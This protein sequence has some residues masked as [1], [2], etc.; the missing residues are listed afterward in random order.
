MT[1]CVRLCNNNS[2]SDLYPKVAQ[3]PTG[4]ESYE[5]LDGHP[6]QQKLLELCPPPQPAN[7]EPVPPLEA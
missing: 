7:Q 5:Y 2:K 6:T 3:L 1:K 4:L